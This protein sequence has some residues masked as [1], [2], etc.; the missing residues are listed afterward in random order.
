MKIM[1]MSGRIL[2]ST[3]I[4]PIERVKRLDLSGYPSGV[5]LIEVRSASSLTVQ[6]L[7]LE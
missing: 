3:T 1:D 5:Y 4:L 2:F 6:K 7:I